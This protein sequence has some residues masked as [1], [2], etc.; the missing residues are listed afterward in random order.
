MYYLLYPMT[1]V[2]FL[3]YLSGIETIHIHLLR[4]CL[5]LFLAYLSGIETEEHLLFI[6]DEASFLAYLSGIE[7]S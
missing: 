6:I 4:F 7:T 1:Q 3:A 2:E 5:H